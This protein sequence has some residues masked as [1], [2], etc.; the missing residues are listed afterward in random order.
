MFPNGHFVALHIAP[1]PTSPD[2]A[3]KVIGRSGR[4]NLTDDIWIERLNPELAVEIMRACEPAHKG[5]QKSNHDMHLYAWVKRAYS[6]DSSVHKGFQPLWA[7]IGLS[8]LVKP[9]TTSLRY[10][11][12]VSELSADAQ[13]IEAIQTVGIGPDVLL[14]RGTEDWLTEED[15]PE[16]HKLMGWLSGDQMDERVFRAYWNHEY[17]LHLYETD[18]RWPF[19]IGGFEALIKSSREQVTA[20]FVQRVAQLA[21]HFNVPLTEQELNIAYDVRSRLVHGEKFLHSLTETL[22]EEDQPVLYRKLEA[23]L[24]TTVKECLLNKSFCADFK[25]DSSVEAWFPLRPSPRRDK[26]RKKR[27]NPAG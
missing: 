12:R 25:D 5:I 20:Q 14:A 4:C 7:S 2:A 23:L 16:I 10:C 11:A 26:H 13:V 1:G 17:A 27:R 22:G 3:L 18:M 21:L 9:T 6:R 8:R 19:I 15:M 24:R